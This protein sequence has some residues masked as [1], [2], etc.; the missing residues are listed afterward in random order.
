MVSNRSES[1]QCL[2]G[3]MKMADSVL[4]NK[5]DNK[6]MSYGAKL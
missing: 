4:R 1:Y 6:F 2:D 3:V 5:S